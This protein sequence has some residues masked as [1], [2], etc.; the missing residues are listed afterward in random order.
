[1]PAKY[2]D[3]LPVLR[4]DRLQHQGLALVDVDEGLMHR[5]VGKQESGDGNEPGGTARLVPDPKAQRVS[6]RHGL[7]RRPA[8]IDEIGA[9]DRQP[10]ALANQGHDRARVRREHRWVE[11]RALGDL[12]LVRDVEHM[13]DDGHVDGVRLDPDVEKAEGRRVRAGWHAAPD[14]QGQQAGNRPHHG[15][16][17]P[18]IVAY[19]T[20]PLR[21]SRRR[22]RLTTHRSRWFLSCVRS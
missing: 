6:I 16:L 12:Q 11:Q 14:E 22:R 7:W 8:A 4:Q 18:S 19:G 10:Q 20:A 9:I 21:C 5:V 3:L 17:W 15:C 13:N 2:L 1:M